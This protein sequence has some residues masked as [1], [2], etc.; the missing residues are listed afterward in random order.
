MWMFYI[1][2]YNIFRALWALMQSYI[3]K[4]FPQKYN[5]Q[6]AMLTCKVS[7]MVVLS[8]SGWAAD[9]VKY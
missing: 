8:Q 7:E 3:C 5:T 9:Y 1:Q 6:L 4:Y 2:L